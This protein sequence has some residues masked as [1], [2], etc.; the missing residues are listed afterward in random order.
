MSPIRKPYQCYKT[1]HYPQINSL[2]QSKY[3]KFHKVKIKGRESNQTQ[4]LM[5]METVILERV[6]FQWIKIEM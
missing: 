2:V 4:V 6:Y 1:C 3:I 5:Y